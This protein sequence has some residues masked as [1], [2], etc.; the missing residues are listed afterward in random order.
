MGMKMGSTWGAA[1]ESGEL[2]TTHPLF[3]P[4]QKKWEKWAS[5]SLNYCNH[6]PVAL[7]TG[8]F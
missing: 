1:L 6:W 2:L 8:C 7:P 5:M 3:V 4:I